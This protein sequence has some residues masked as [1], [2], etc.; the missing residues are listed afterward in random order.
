MTE[1]CGKFARLA[2]SGMQEERQVRSQGNV[3][4]LPRRRLIRLGFQSCKHIPKTPNPKPFR[5]CRVRVCE[6]TNP[7]KKSCRAKVSSAEYWHHPGASPKSRNP[8][9]LN[10]KGRGPPIETRKVFLLLEGICIST[11][12]I[13]YLSE[14]Q[15]IVVGKAILV[16][17]S[18]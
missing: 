14:Q 13:G 7:T 18:N 15:L 11:V 12:F 16:I 1:A 17:V 5:A 8:F 2:A 10:I 9:P 4:L 6:S 3:A